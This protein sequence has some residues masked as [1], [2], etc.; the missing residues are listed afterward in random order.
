MAYAQSIEFK[1]VRAM[2]V[3]FYGLMFLAVVLI[4]SLPFLMSMEG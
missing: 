1:I 4:T 2:N 3:T